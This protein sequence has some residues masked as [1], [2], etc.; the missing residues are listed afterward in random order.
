MECLAR[1]GDIPCK[2]VS[3]ENQWFKASLC[4][5]KLKKVNLMKLS[6]EGKPCHYFGHKKI[7]AYGNPVNNSRRT[8]FRHGLEHLPYGDLENRLMTEEILW[9]KNRNQSKKRREQPPVLIEG[10]GGCTCMNW[11]TKFLPLYQAPTGS[12]VKWGHFSNEELACMKG[13]QNFVSD[14]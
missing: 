11:V 2:P 3:Q 7:Y 10:Q 6:G 5:Q 13:W 12:S 9:L 14:L 1:H 8:A 4:L